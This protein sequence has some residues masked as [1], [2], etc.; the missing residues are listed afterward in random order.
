LNETLKLG[1]M[2]LLVGLLVWGCTR[3]RTAGP[4]ASKPFAASQAKQGPGF[5]LETLGK[6]QVSLEGLRGQVVLLDFWATW[7]PPCRKMCG[8][9]QALHE[10]YKDRGLTVIGVS[11]DKEGPAVVAPYVKQHGLDYMMAFPTQKLLDGYGPI[12][13][14]PMLIVLDQEGRIRQRLVGVHRKADLE[15]LVQSLLNE[16]KRSPVRKK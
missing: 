7:C 11:F 1:L 13:S 5:K 4:P 12:D 16:V 3:R 15:A 9:L 2:A 14:I 6:R 8:V 10:S